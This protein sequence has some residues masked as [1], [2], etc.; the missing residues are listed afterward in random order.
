VL[1]GILFAQ[2]GALLEQLATDRPLV[3]FLDDLH[4]IDP[5]SLD[6]LESLLPLTERVPLMVIVALRDSAHHRDLASRW[7]AMALGVYGH[8][9]T[10]VALAPLD[11]GQSR[12]LVAGLLRIEDLPERVRRLI[13]AKAEGNPFF[14]EEVIRSL[15]D[16]HLVVRDDGHWRATAEVA[17]LALPDTLNGVITA[18]LDRLPEGPR[19]FAQAAAVGRDFVRRLADVAAKRGAGGGQPVQ[20]DPICEKSPLP[21]ASSRSSIAHP[22]CRLPLVLLSTRRS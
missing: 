13:L 15:L 16:A 4:W 10:A 2:A 20:R 7:R 11:A 6:L 22:G 21:S 3:I 19:Q 8:R 9:H 14:V 17:D 18:R 1:R 12:E 5:T